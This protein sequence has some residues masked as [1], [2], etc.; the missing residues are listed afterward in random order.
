MFGRGGHSGSLSVCWG[1]AIA[2]PAATGTEAKRE[3]NVRAPGE[4]RFDG[5]VR[6]VDAAFPKPNE[7][8]HHFSHRSQL[9]LGSLVLRSGAMQ[10]RTTSEL[11]AN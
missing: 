4:W 6:M 3:Q 10:Q 5:C 7:Y 2:F 8:I 11:A 1:N 9:G